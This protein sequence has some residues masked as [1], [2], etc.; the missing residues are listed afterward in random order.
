LAIAVWLF[1]LIVLGQS[2]VASTCFAD[3]LQSSNDTSASVA[4]T[5]AP[6]TVDNT[7][8]S[9][10]PCW[11]AGSGGCHCTCMHSSGLPVAGSTV[12]ADYVATCVP[13]A[14]LTATY[15]VRLTTELRP[16]IA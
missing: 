13:L 6:S 12:V 2:A 14:A 16:P 4:A 10:A 3:G 15:F 5:Q 9:E 7:D 11:H 1:A 8:N